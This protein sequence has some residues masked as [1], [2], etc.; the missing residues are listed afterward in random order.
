MRVPLII[1]GPGV[2]HGV[3]NALAGTVDL[4]PTFEQW[5]GVAPD[6][7]RD[8]RSLTPLLRGEHP[9]SWRSALLIEHSEAGVP[10]GDPDVQGWAGGKPPSYAALRTRWTT[11]VEYANGD[12]EF[13]DRRHDPYELHNCVRQ[14]SRAQIARLHAA[15]DAYCHCAGA[16]EAAAAGDI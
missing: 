1:V 4:A 16:A 13:Y 2:R 11:Y 14:L 5:A 8:G 10:V 3:S 7:H 12:R 9:R 15:L 6:A